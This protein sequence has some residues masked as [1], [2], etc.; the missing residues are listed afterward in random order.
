MTRRFLKLALCLVAVCALVVAIPMAASANKHHRHKA[1][2][3]SSNVTRTSGGSGETPITGDTLT[4]ASNAALA[5]TG[6]GT[7]DRATTDNEDGGAYEVFVTTT[8]GH[9][10]KVVEDANF[11][12]LSVTSGGG[13]H[14]GG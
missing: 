3:S 10:V 4:Q 11:N 8:D 6:G 9:H 2:R 12:V 1:H 14:S 7:V 5:A 13:C